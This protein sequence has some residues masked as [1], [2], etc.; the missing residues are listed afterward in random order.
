MGVHATEA[1][2]NLRVTLGH[3]TTRAEVD[4]FV[5]AIGPVVERA[6]MQSIGGGGLVRIRQD[7]AGSH[8]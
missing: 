4:A 5:G 1:R 6:R 8:G 3:T 7:R 2:S